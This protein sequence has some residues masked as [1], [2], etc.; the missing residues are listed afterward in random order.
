M[1]VGSKGQLELT[2]PPKK[3]T[4]AGEE[5]GAFIGI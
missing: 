3:E 1:L 5:A 2:P 4:E